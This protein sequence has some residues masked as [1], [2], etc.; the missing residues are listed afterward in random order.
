M[1]AE[2]I[3]FEIPDASQMARESRMAVEESQAI[4]VIDAP[5]Y[6]LA[7]ERVKGLASLKKHI[8]DWF[9]PLVKQANQA[10]KALTGRRAE[11]LKPIEAEEAR[12]RREMTAWNAEQQR[13][14][15]EE[16][17]RLA[18][19]AKRREEE[20]ALQEAAMLQAQGVS[21]AEAMA[22][23]EQAIAAPAPIITLPTAAPKVDGISYRS[24]WRWQVDNEAAVP[25]EYLSVN[26]KAIGGVVRALKGATRIPGV[27]VWEEKTPVVRAS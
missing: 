27:R 23:V 11:E 6:A 12:L 20:F 13:R 22:V 19:E 26:E 1:N 8:T 2:I 3:S 16:E 5:S 17:A 4:R 7:A 9:E 15:R 10:H 24:E 25:R 14:Q 18:A 21:E